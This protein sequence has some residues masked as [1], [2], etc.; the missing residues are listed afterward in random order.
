[1]IQRVGLAFL[2]AMAICAWAFHA[3]AYPGGGDATEAFSCYGD[4]AAGKSPSTG[5]PSCFCDEACNA[6]G[7]CCA[8]RNEYCGPA[9]SRPAC[10][11]TAP[12]GN[13]NFC[14]T[15]LGFVYQHNGVLE[16]LFGDSWEWPSSN[17]TPLSVPNTPIA[18]ECF[19]R[20]TTGRTDDTRGQM[21]LTRPSTTLGI[22]QRAA[23]LPAL[24]AGSDCGAIL[25]IDLDPAN[26]STY[27]S[28]RLLDP[29]GVERRM[30]PAYT[31]LAGFS[32]GTSAYGVFSAIDPGNQL[33]VYIGKRDAG[34]TATY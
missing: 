14:G 22:P 13:A 23:H 8:D 33:S 10:S 25:A 1:M 16:V 12:N 20:G 11:L 7:D 3:D 28:F 6:R 5:T 31:P 18:G 26:P 24:P 19:S 29:N 30:P 32:D 21:S 34:N 17:H 15:D 9:V 27:R 2:V 4:C